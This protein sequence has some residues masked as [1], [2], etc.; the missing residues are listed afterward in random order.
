MLLYIF[1]W[2]I[3]LK[4]SSKYLFLGVR[5][6][7]ATTMHDVGPRCHHLHHDCVEPLSKWSHRTYPRFCRQEVRGHNCCWFLLERQSF[8]PCVSRPPLL[9]KRADTRGIS[10][11]GWGQMLIFF[12][13]LRSATGEMCSCVEINRLLF[14]CLVCYGCLSGVLGGALSRFLPGLPSTTSLSLMADGKCLCLLCFIYLVFTYAKLPLCNVLYV[15]WAN[16]GS[17]RMAVLCPGRRDTDHFMIIYQGLYNPRIEWVIRA[18]FTGEKKQ[19]KVWS[20]PLRIK[21]LV[22]VYC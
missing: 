7:R 19:A 8:P 22:F 13:F 15:D 20:I 21:L 16:F 11:E 10:D 5:W 18:F 4:I 12:L 9:L 14:P 3:S 17:R 2:L 6:H 1:I